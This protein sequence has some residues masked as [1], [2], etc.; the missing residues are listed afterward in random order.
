MKARRVLYGIA[1]VLTIVA[2]G[3]FWYVRAMTPKLE[4]G[5]AY[6]ARVACG[7]HYI[8]HRP[9]KSCYA[10]FEA[11]MEPISLHD[12]PASRTVTASVPV[13]AHRSAR[14]DP[15]LGCQPDRFE[16]SPVKVHGHG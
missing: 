8:E 9:L 13:I 14:F 4:L 2:V 3:T 6:A 11:G 16:G 7:C 15:V 5:V 1:A 10:D 12:D